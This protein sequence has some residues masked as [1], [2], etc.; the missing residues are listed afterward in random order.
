VNVLR[1]LCHQATETS[2]EPSFV[3]FAVFFLDLACFAETQRA[4][5]EA[6]RQRTFSFACLPTT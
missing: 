2:D 3:S 6:H 4:S 1:W 5:P